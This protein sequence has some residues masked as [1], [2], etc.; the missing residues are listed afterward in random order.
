MQLQARRPAANVIMSDAQRRAV[1]LALASARE[2]PAH[3]SGGAG[4]SSPGTPA[5]LG[6]GADSA[7]DVQEGRWG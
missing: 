7:A 3:P 4:D 5:A 2:Q 6:A 1:D